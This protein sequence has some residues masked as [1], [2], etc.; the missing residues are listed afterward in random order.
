MSTELRRSD[1]AAATNAPPLHGATV[2]DLTGEVTVFVSTL[3]GPAYKACMDHL[4]LQDSRFALQVIDGVAP[5]SRAFQLMLD[6]CTTP[7][8]VQ[9]D[10]DMLLFARAIRT[11]YE[12]IT[13]SDSSV[14][15]VVGQLYDVHLERPIDGVKIFRHEAVARYPWTEYRTVFA[16]NEQLARDGW[17]ISR[18]S[19]DGPG[20][21]GLLGLHGTEWTPQ[22]IYERY[23]SLERQRRAHPREL[24]W[25]NEYAFTFL[26]RFREHPDE[27]SFF[28][29]MGVLAGSVGAPPADT[30]P[31]DIREIRSRK[32][33]FDG[34]LRYWRAVE[35]EARAGEPARAGEVAQTD[36]AA[37][38]DAARADAVAAPAPTAGD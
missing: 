15:I 25:F 19:L 9:V 33:T 28:A 7:W 11:L 24:A 32:G 17:S 16:R 4:E 14:A 22:S 23:R 26:G 21:R 20:Q 27:T 38:A 37:R 6:R 29:L 3:Y 1:P 2:P 34:L 12:A 30:A 35:A 31:P 18:L 5:A 10:E 13:S 36:E 8:Y